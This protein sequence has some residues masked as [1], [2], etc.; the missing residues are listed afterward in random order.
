MRKIAINFFFFLFFLTP[1]AFAQNEI[2]AEVN[3]TK[4]TTDEVLTYTLIIS[5]DEKK[6]PQPQLPDF[7]GL[8]IIS[9]AQSSQM[10]LANGKMKVSLV[11]AYGL[12]APEPG[13]FEIKPSSIKIGGKTY[14]T[15]SFKIEVSKGEGEP[16]AFRPK[17]SPA[18]PKRPQPEPENAAP[19]IIL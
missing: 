19:E 13:K 18:L 5:S 3:K 4:L 12:A 16:P 2:K 15:D 6:I 10:S 1:L 9:Q 8:S 11:Y 7:K 14:S 17:E